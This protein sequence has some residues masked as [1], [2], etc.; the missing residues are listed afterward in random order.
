[1]RIWKYPLF[2]CDWQQVDLPE[3]AEAVHLQFQ[4]ELVN[5]WAMVDVKQ[6]KITMDVYRIAT[7]ETIPARA[8]YIGTVVMPDGIVWHYFWRIS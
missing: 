3:G 2:L 5:L 8:T 7:G 6:P 1:M 4:G